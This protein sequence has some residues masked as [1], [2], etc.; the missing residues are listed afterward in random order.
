MAKYSETYALTLVPY[1]IMVHLIAMDSEPDSG[2]VLAFAPRYDTEHWDS[3][4]SVS[5]GV[6]R[7]CV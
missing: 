5:L 6:T 4:H 1:N 7:F 3:K 2:H